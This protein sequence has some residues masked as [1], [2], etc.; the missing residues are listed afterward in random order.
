MGV[1]RSPLAAT[2]EREG[3]AGVGIAPKSGAS[4][5]SASND[6]ILCLSRIVQYLGKHQSIRLH[7]V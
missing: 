4:F 3:A 2:I 5:L 6:Q 7:T 1:T